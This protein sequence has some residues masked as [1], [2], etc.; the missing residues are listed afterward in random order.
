V[1]L[2]DALVA[3]GN[4]WKAY[5]EDTNPPA[6]DQPPT[7]RHPVPG[8]TDDGVTWRDPFVY[9]HS[10]IDLEGC[11]QTVVGLDQLT[12]D[13][14][15]ADQ[16]PSLSYIVPNRC[17]DAS[18]EPCAPDQ[19]AGLPAADTFLQDLIPRITDSP[20]Y[21]DG[22]LI[23][24]TF[25]AAPQDGPEADSSACC[26]EP[27][28]PNMPPS[29]PTDGTSTAPAATTP[30]PPGADAST[31]G[32]GRVGLLLISP[33]VKAGSTNSVTAFNHYGL[34]RSIE[35]LFGL[36]PTGYAGYPGLV[37]FDNVVYN[38]PASTR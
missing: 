6:A 13:L 17:H 2:A 24:I 30:L 21:K 27:P 1:T 3:N 22:G 34:L 36:Q 9:F 33:F 4:T 31:G 28:Y 29:A 35:D 7:C 18:D 5:V 32:G 25:A 37:A 15:S 16:T 26:T 23:A 19:P 10:V 20:A 14:A 8:A 11:A 38:A 12:T